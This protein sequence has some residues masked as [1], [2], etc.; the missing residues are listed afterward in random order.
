MQQETEKQVTLDHFIELSMETVGSELKRNLFKNNAL[1]NKPLTPPWP[2]LTK[3]VE[4]LEIK[5][6]LVSN[7]DNDDLLK[8]RLFKINRHKG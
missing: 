8:T 2:S 4:N 7:N 1:L 5:L 6:D 3:E